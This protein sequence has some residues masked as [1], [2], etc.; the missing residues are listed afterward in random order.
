MPCTG[1]VSAPERRGPDPTRWTCQEHDNGKG[2]M[3]RHKTHF[4]MEIRLCPFTLEM[5]T[6]VGQR[7]LR[8]GVDY[9]C[10]L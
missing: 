6:Y 9:Q 4:Q 7:C 10:A 8:N 2:V 5:I 3:R 1:W